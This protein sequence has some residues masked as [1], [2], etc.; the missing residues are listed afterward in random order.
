MRT[1]L[2]IGLCLLLFA[3]P[4]SAEKGKPAGKGAFRGTDLLWNLDSLRRCPA[5]EWTGAKGPVRSLL[6]RSV[7]YGGKPTR[8]FAY[9]SN[10]DL[11]MGRAP[12]RRKF[13][14]VVLLHGGAGRAF[15][16]WVEK[17]AADGY[18]ALAL[19][20]SGQGE[21]GARMP[22]GGPDLSDTQ[23]VFLNA[24]NGDMRSMWTYH[25]AATAVL[26]HSLLLS[27]PEVDRDKTCLTGISWG[28]YLTCIVAALD[29]RF[30]AAAPVYGCGYYDRLPFFGYGMDALSEAGRE[31]WMK[32]LDA[33]VY[34]PYVRIPMLF[35]NGNRDTAYDLFAHSRSCRL[36]ADSLRT[37]CIRPDMQHGYY[38]GWE[39]REIRCFFESVVN[40]GC[41]LIDI[42]KTTVGEQQVTM[43]F[44]SRISPYRA[45]FYY[46]NDTG[47]DNVNRKWER[48][49]ARIDASGGVV[50]CPLPEEGFRIGFFV[51]DDVRLLA[52]SGGFIMNP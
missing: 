28:G 21:D 20:L 6:M 33:S 38:E 7:D 52:V 18:A 34:L 37:I 48:R 32:Y 2:F 40:G 45:F 9:Y 47:P 46:T 13:P 30:R 50:T 3:G 12:G 1:T 10:P 17:W 4:V 42:G 26:G 27:L 14:A 39:P 44:D 22:D 8:A 23:Q 43:A 25:A 11:L 41:P 5:F 16:E 31:R 51:I 36:V 49:A 19:D 35:V 15:R 24:E 29:D